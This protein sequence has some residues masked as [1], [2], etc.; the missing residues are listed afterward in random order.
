M[1]EQG[2]ETVSHCHWGKWPAVTVEHVHVHSGSQAIV[3]ALETG[4]GVAHTNQRQPHAKAISRSPNASL[5]P[6]RGED[7]EREPV[8]V[9]GNAERPL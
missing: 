3:G 7:E 8:P 6:L 5:P 9:T 2:G 1:A 4:G